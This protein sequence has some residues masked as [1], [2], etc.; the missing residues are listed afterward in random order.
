M[1]RGAQAVRLLRDP[2]ALH[3]AAAAVAAHL[4]PH[5]AAAA[6]AAAAAD[7]EEEEQQALERA[8]ALMWELHVAGVPP[9]PVAVALAG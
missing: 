6:A 7:E 2:A 3:E 4:T 5:A 9:R 1:V 8:Y